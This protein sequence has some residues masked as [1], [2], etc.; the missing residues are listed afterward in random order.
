MDASSKGN[1][2]KRRVSRWSSF[3]M[4]LGLLCWAGL[5]LWFLVPP[6]K[7]FVEGF[8]TRFV[9][10]V[11]VA[12]VAPL[13]NQASFSVALALMVALVAGFPLLWAANWIYLRAIKGRSHWRGFFWGFQWAFFI[14]P[15]IAVWFLVFWAAGYQRLAVEERLKLDTEAI[16][17]E[18]AA[19]LRDQLIEVILRDQPETP[20]DRDTDRAL[21]AV[22]AAMKDTIKE[23]DGHA[24][25]LPSGVKATPKGLLLANGTSGICTPYTLEPHVDGGMPDT[26]FVSTGAHELGHIAGMCTEAE[27]TLIGFVAG[28]RADDAYARYAVALDMY[29]DLVRQ[30]P[31]EEQQ[32]AM[33]RLPDVAREDLKAAREAAARYRIEW[34]QRSSWKVYDKYLQA[35]GIKEGV[36]NYG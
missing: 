4:G 2:P 1:Q 9:Y 24:I 13:T 26:A 10:R 8:Y 34:F 31:R 22:A 11:I 20:E 15:I 33:E 28:M 14:A 17:D 3:W 25:W 23:W 30:L 19:L 5:A 36:K 27:A 35:Q 7:A 29:T 18:Q 21:A 16:G 12:G 32:A 6:P